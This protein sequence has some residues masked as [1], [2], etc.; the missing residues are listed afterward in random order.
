MYVYI[1]SPLLTVFDSASLVSAHRGRF[2]ALS[3][4][5]SSSSWSEPHSMRSC[6]IRSALSSSLAMVRLS[7]VP[8][9]AGMAVVGG[10]EQSV[11]ES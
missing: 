11:S 5:I 10:C 3:N 4:T 9:S 2:A 7:G 6:L 1:N 8:A